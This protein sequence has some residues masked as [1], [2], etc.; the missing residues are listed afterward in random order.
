MFTTKGCRLLNA[1]RN[2][3]RTPNSRP[4]FTGLSGLPRIPEAIGAVAGNWSRKHFNA[5][6]TEGYTSHSVTFSS[7]GYTGPFFMARNL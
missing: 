1:F 3:P 4:V 7:N 6:S 2:V 5:G